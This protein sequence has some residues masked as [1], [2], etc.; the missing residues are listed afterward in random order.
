MYAQTHACARARVH[1]HS[2]A[3]LATVYIV[4]N[5]KSY[6]ALGGIPEGIE[7]NTCIS[8]LVCFKNILAAK[9]SGFPNCVVWGQ[10]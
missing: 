5:L 1:T 8:L 9:M 7:S 3:N 10:D 4:L 6:L 2:H